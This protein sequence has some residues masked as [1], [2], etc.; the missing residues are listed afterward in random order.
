MIF[1]GTSASRLKDGQL[2]NVECPNCNEH[3]HMN[4]SVF[5]RYAYLYWIPVFPLGKSN[6]LECHSCKKTF[7]LKELP[8]RLKAKFETEKHTGIPL[9]H[10]SG[11][12]II[13][14]AIAY[15]SYTSA[16]HKDLEADFIKAPAVGDLYSLTT[17]NKGH[18]SSMKVIDVKGDSVFVVFN[19]YEIDKRT[20]IDQIDKPENY[21]DVTDAFSQQEL[22]H[23]YMEK[24]IYAIDRD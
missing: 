16:K 23:L 4:Y 17:E 1:Y 5:G 22:E 11:L 12:A 8:Q 7:K 3:T 6:I 20:G 10:F 15:F 24:T 18:Y 2:K 13:L 21:S 19:N 9:L 14:I